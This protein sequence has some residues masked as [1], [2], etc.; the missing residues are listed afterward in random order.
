LN[1]FT[2]N[3]QLTEHFAGIATENRKKKALHP[4]AGA[5][6]LAHFRMMS[7]VVWNGYQVLKDNGAVKETTLVL[8]AKECT[9]VPL[10]KLAAEGPVYLVDVDVESLRLARSKLRDPPLRDR[11]EIVPMDASLF[12][13]VLLEEA[14]RLFFENPSDIDRAF[15][16]VAAM[17]RDAGQGDLGLFANTRLPINK[18]SVGLAV[19]SMTLSQFMIGYVQLLVKMFLA[20][21]GREKAREYFLS[22]SPEAASLG[23]SERID[24]LQN[25]TTALARRAAEKH[26]RELRRIAKSGGVVVLSDHAL[27][28]RCTLIR[29]DEVEVDMESLIP[30]SKNRGEEK[31]P[32][33]REDRGRRLPAAF[34]VDST[35]PDSFFIVEGEDSLRNIV[36]RDNRTEILD[37]QGWWWVTEQLKDTG[38]GVS[39][40]SISYVEAFTLQAKK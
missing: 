24:E 22:P 35:K 20:Q 6:N 18:D 29:E 21:F 5:H 27:H 16:A 40:W 12:E 38:A 10:D 9:D 39:G 32:R 34:R 14:H 28:G 23:G 33:F 36:D 31:I 17:N 26:I 1:E 2:P 3:P 15:Q 30:Y 19:S 7:S 4:D 37:Q 13:N 8:G 11:V 25:S